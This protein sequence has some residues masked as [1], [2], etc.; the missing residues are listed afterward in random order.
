MFIYRKR[1]MWRSIISKIKHLGVK[2]LF[3]IA[4]LLAY[5]VLMLFSF[6][7]RFAV[8]LYDWVPQWATALGVGTIGGL[9]CAWKTLPQLRMENKPF[10]DIVQPFF[11]GLC[12]FGIPGLMYHDYMVW[13]FPKKT[14]SYVTDYDVTFPGPSRGKHGHCEAG[15]Q[16]K[17]KTLGHWITLCS[18]KEAL[19][20]Q[21]KQG[22]D[23]IFVV[24]QVGHYGIRLISTTF[25]WKD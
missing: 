20:Q 21:R 2:G 11:C 23:G 25:T 18:S 5:F 14:V 12:F 1:N 19:R 22:M 6:R 8:F 10:W 3:V 24:E 17:D 9:W 13:F 4:L 15:L 7:F 16:I